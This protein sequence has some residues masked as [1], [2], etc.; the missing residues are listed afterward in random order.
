M[1]GV[2]GETHQFEIGLHFREEVE[3][4]TSRRVVGEVLFPSSSRDQGR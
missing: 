1:I 3:V 4:L 2:D